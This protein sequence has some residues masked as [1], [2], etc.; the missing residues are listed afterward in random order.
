MTS[1]EVFYNLGRHLVSV[2]EYWDLRQ[3]V[4]AS[5]KKIALV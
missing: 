5:W 2:R 1:L 3:E 4:F